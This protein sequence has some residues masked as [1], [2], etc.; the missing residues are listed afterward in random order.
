ME[1]LYLETSV[2]SFYYDNRLD[3]EVVA[4]RN[5]TRQFWENCVGRHSMMTGSAVL[6]ELSKGAKLHKQDAL[7]LALSLPSV[8]VNEDIKEI[9][10]VYVHHLVMPKDPLGDALHLALASYWKFDYLVTWNCRH[11]A[12]A[13]K[14]SHIKRINA[15]LD[16]RTPAMITPLELSGEK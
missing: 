1:K 16:L 4:R 5:W 10:A 6:V 15:G 12:N 3:P 13:N 9:A 7:N 11:L 14:I 8:D 2:F